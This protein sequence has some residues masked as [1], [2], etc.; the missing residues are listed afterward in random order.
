MG[1]RK[2]TKFLE[3]Q[4]KRIQKILIPAQ[5]AKIAKKSKKSLKSKT[6]AYNC[7][8]RGLEVSSILVRCDGRV[9]RL[10]LP[11][12]ILLDTLFAPK[13][14]KAI[15]SVLSSLLTSVS[16]VAHV[17]PRHTVLIFVL[18]IFS[19]SALRFVTNQTERINKDLL[20][21]HQSCRA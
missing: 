19:L 7:V 12:L 2:A 4:K 18:V 16:L 9:C 21:F 3:C 10:Q 17:V 14:H 1:V 15:S 20:V 13:V 5:M 11:T 8:L 6:K